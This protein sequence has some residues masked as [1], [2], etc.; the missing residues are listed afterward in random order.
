MTEFVQL[1]EEVVRDETMRRTIRNPEFGKRRG[2]K[3]RKDLFR[4]DKRTGDIVLVNRVDRED[5]CKNSLVCNV[6]LKVSGL[7][8]C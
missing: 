8:F 4:T 6:V 5:I 2:R 7:W 1:V 3:K